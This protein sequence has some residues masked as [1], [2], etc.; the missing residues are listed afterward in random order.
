MSGSSTRSVYVPR[1]DPYLL[2]ASDFNALIGQIGQRISWMRSHSCPCVWAPSFMGAMQTVNA[3]GQPVFGSGGFPVFPSGAVAPTTRLS[4]PGSAQKQCLTCLGVG[5]YWDLPTVPFQAVMTFRHISPS[6]DEPGVREDPKFGVDQVSEP[7]L[8]IPYVNPFLDLDDVRQP[9]LPWTYASTNDIFVAVDMLARYTTMLQSG[10]TENLPFQQNLQIAPVG[11]VVTWNPDTRMIAP[12]SGYV[13]S[14]ATVTLPAGFASGTS[15]M[16]EFQAAAL[17]VAFRR[18]GGLPHD[19]P[20]G[21]GTVNLPKAF[22]VQAL[23]FWT[24]QRG[25]QPQINIGGTPLAW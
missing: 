24:R 11:A 17:F 13:V 22:R 6:P 8:T 12:V 23:D 18:A 25:L 16:V 19:R 14:G 20:F 4:T 15:Y 1:T 10:V 2:P 7:S 21:G 9:T 3:S 5:T